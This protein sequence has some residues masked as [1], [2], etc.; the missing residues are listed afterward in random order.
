MFVNRKGTSDSAGPDDYNRTY[1]VDGK[2]G[3][4]EAVT[5]SGF[6]AKTETPGLSGRG[7]RL[8]FGLRVQD[9]HLRDERELRGGGR[10]LQSGGG[11]PRTARRL[12][13][14]HHGAAPAHSDAALAK[15][16]LREFEPHMSYESYWGFDGLQET[17]TLHLDGRWDFESGYTIGSAA[18]NV[19]YEGLREPFEVYPGVVVPAGN[20]RSP[21]FLGNA[22]TDRRKW[23]SGSLAVE[24]R[25]LPVGQPGRPLRRR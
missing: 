12:S 16:G 23:I 2:L 9:A 5:I 4:R 19:Q 1:S 25:R 8:Q 22:N 17:A 24:H 3:L 10:Q 15:L 20:Y 11:L 18:L 7:L 14:G 21:Y 13:A 6:G